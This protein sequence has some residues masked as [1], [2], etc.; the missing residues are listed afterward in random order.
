VLPPPQATS[1]PA[2]NTATARAVDLGVRICTF[3][4]AVERSKRETSVGPVLE[5]DGDGRG[6]RGA[7]KF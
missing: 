1:G 7:S 4:M 3:I 6:R 5:P 2:A